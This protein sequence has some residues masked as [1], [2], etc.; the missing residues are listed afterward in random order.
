M[1]GSTKAPLAPFEILQAALRREKNAYAFYDGLLKQ[2]TVGF[3]A[4]MLEELRDAEF[5]HVK[6]IEK[7]IIAMERG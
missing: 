4:D 5:H 2:A 3:L 7:M 6:M 1:P